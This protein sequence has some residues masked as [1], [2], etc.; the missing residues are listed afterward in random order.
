MATIVDEP[1][2]PVAG[3]TAPVDALKQL[4]QRP[5]RLARGSARIGL[6]AAGSAFVAIAVAVTLWTGLGP[7]PLDVFIGAV[8]TR[9]GLP[10]G[11]AV[12]AVIGAVT[13]LAWSLGRRPGPATLVGPLVVGPVMQVAV[14]VLDTIDVPDAYV[15]RLVIHAVAVAGIGLGAGAIIASGLGAGSA[16]LLTIAAS[17]R[18]DRPRPHVR[19]VVEVTWITL[20]VVLGG[21]IGLGT[22]LV[23]LMIGP[24][25]E[26]GYRVVSR[27]AHRGV[28]AGGAPG[29]R[30]A[31]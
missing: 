28:L 19:L 22:V 9:T 20:G 2:R 23:A 24:A 3:P 16:E 15:V 30:L 26:S 29:A 17:D 1:A 18:L 31:A 27:L 21:P 10:L 8:R 25:V 4:E 13:A 6:V 14:G 11:L 5:A 12:W 7:G